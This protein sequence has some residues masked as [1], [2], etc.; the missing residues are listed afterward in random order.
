MGQSMAMASCRVG[1]APCLKPA[2]PA[3]LSLTPII[4]GLLLGRCN[5]SPHH[6]S[7]VLLVHVGGILT[8]TSLGWTP[9]PGCA[10]DMAR[11]AGLG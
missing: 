11:W 9:R 10:S 6:T 3:V 8:L 2:V 1:L 7:P 4:H 5:F